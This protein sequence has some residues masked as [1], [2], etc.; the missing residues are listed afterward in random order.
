M[1][2]E[3]VPLIDGDGDNDED[4]NPNSLAWVDVAWVAIHLAF[5]SK[6]VGLTRSGGDECLLARACTLMASNRMQVATAWRCVRC[7]SDDSRVPFFLAAIRS[8]WAIGLSFC[9]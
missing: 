7:Y 8:F 9:R 1:G 5:A 4:D 6:C 2:T 3:R